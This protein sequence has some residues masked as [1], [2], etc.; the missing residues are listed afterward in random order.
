MP[1][2]PSRQL[3]PAQEV[4]LP[5]HN[6]TSIPRPTPSQVVWNSLIVREEVL[7]CFEVPY[8]EKALS[9]LY[10]DL[11]HTRLRFSHRKG[12]SS[13]AILLPD[14]SFSCVEGFGWDGFAES[15]VDNAYPRLQYHP[16]RLYRGRDSIV[17]VCL[18]A[19]ILP[20]AS[21]SI[22]NPR[23]SSPRKTPRHVWTPRITPIFPRINGNRA[24]Y[25]ISAKTTPQVPPNSSPSK[26]L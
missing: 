12:D 22:S 16:F 7:L 1:I 26:A 10:M 6:A 24:L 23:L 14:F 20:T 18:K 2:H 25:G 11:C 3:Q 19:I 8:L 17:L 5:F 9:T 13:I 4:S 21:L 15:H